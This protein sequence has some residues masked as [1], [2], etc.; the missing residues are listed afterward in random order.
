MRIDIDTLSEADLIDLNHRLIERLRFLNQM[1]AHTQML[2]FRI[3]DRVMFQPEGRVPIEG[4]IVRQD[5]SRMMTQ[6][7]SSTEGIRTL[8]SCNAPCEQKAPLIWR[9]FF[10]CR[11][12]RCVSALYIKSPFIFYLH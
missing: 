11:I 9:G 5:K 7:P 12:R 2:E 1:R 8:D 10:L 4:M 3:G 6:P